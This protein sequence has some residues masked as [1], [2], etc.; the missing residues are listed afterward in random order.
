MSQIFIAGL[1][2]QKIGIVKITLSILNAIISP[3]F[4]PFTASYNIHTVM[5]ENLRNPEE[6]FPLVLHASSHASLLVGSNLRSH[7]TELPVVKE[8]T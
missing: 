2:L 3:Y 8:M 5:C 6:M 1:L 7:L 4:K